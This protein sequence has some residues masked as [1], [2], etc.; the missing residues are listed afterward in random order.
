MYVCVVDAV[1]IRTA[2]SLSADIVDQYTRGQTVILDDNFTEADGC[3]WGTYIAFSGN[4]R[5]IAISQNGET[6]FQHC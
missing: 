3:V 1:R 6:Y 5:Y 2:P 4:R